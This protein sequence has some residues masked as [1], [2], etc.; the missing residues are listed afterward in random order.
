MLCSCMWFIWLWVCFVVSCR[1][2]SNDVLGL[3]K[4]LK[5]IC[6]L[7]ERGRRMYLVNWLLKTLLGERGFRL[8]VCSQWFAMQNRL[9][10]TC[11][12]I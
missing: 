3:I 1:E 2:K 12:L 5:C 7:S 11:K 6:H 8:Y 10:G 9:L 4:G